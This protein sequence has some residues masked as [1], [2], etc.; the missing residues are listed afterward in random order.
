MSRPSIELQHPFIV[1]GG[2]HYLVRE[3]QNAYSRAQCSSYD[4]ISRPH[5]LF[6]SATSCARGAIKFIASDI[7]ETKWRLRVDRRIHQCGLLQL[8]CRS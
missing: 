6:T 1:P 3:T 2:K 7:R 5:P 4:I 8:T